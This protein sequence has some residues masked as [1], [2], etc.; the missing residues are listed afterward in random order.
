ME[1]KWIG[2]NDIAVLI[3]V[4]WAVVVVGCG[5]YFVIVMNTSRC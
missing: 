5:I 4:D 3:D 1:R 2:I